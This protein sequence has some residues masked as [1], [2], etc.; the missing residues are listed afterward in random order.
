M[1]KTLAAIILLAISAGAFAA[2]FSIGAGGAIESLTWLDLKASSGPATFESKF[3]RTPFEVKVYADVTILQLSVGYLFMSGGSY[4]STSTGASTPTDWMSYITFAA[5]GKYPFSFGPVSIFP[6]IGM[7]YRLNLWW[8]DS[9]G[10]DLKAALPSQWQSSLNELWLQGGAGVDVNF[11]RFY[12][13]SEL[14]LGFKAAMST[15][16]TDLLTPFQVPGVTSSMSY[17][18]VNVDFLAGYK[19]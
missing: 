5:Y 2:D 1:K 14:L 10:N 17:F 11:G 18:T 9:S 15:M 8:K 16:D 6:L 12:V 19:L 7:E 3:N 13:R 4:Y